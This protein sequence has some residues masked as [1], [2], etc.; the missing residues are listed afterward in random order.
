M[1]T[2]LL[3][4]LICCL[5][6]GHAHLDAQTLCGKGEHVAFSCSVSRKVAS[7]C[8]AGKPNEASTMFYRFGSPNK[9]ELSYPERAILAKKVFTS[10]PNLYSYDGNVVR[11][12]VG[13]YMYSLYR[14]VEVERG[15]GI[16]VDSKLTESGLTV[17]RDG[18]LV[19]RLICTSSNSGTREWWNIAI[20]EAAL[21]TDAQ[22]LEEP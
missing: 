17:R 22:Y 1:K 20:Q 18:K 12:R 7:L 14:P 3:S 13:K 4:L 11:F 21:E 19:S 2:Q 16:T 5:L 8:V 6:F 9:V 10:S 15:G